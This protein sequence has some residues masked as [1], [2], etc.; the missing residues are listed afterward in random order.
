MGI[1]RSKKGVT[2]VELIAAI[3]IIAIVVVGTVTGVV[4]AQQNIINDSLKEKAS[5]QAQQIADA[6]VAEFSGH[7]FGDNQRAAQSGLDAEITGGA[8]YSNAVTESG[9]PNNTL[10]ASIQYAVLEMVE[11]NPPS[12]VSDIKMAGT[13]ILVA[14]Y[15]KDNNYI[16]AEA[17]APK[18]QTS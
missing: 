12:A 1:K 8:V 6:L 14:V 15:Y 17:F 7:S 18:D 11:N 10:H 13:R 5:L 3:A 4:L 2:L 16:T 9:F